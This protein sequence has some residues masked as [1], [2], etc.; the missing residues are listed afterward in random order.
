MSSTKSTFN[1]FFAFKGLTEFASEEQLVVRGC[2]ELVA[3]REI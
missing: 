2:E 1:N 3:C